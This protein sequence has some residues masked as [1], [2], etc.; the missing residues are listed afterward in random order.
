ML[1]HNSVQADL[2]SWHFLPASIQWKTFSVKLSSMNPYP[3]IT[4]PLQQRYALIKIKMISVLSATILMHLP[5]LIHLTHPH[6]K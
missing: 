6:S 1:F 4:P 3:V 2:S 5:I